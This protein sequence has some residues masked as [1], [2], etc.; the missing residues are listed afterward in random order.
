MAVR[1]SWLKSIDPKVLLRWSVLGKGTIHL[2][3]L[4]ER[5]GRNASRLFRRLAANPGIWLAKRTKVICGSKGAKGAFLKMRGM[6]VSFPEVEARVTAIPVVYECVA[7]ATNHP[8][9]VEALVLFIVPDP[10]RVLGW[11]KFAATC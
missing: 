7:R 5:F 3:R 2:L 11:K 1:G 4:L 8:E 9:A 6:R 10:G